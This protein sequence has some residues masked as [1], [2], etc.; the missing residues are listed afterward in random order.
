MPGI[1]RVLR[2]WNHPVTLVTRGHTVL[3]DL[4]L[5]AEMAAKDQAMV[6]V[7]VTTLDVDLSRAMEPRAP[8]PA[9]RLKMIREL[10]RAGSRCG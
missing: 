8:A 2:D 9:T 7:S 1:L 10:A 6:G 3:R 4:D 5:W